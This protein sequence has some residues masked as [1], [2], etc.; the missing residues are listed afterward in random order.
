VGWPGRRGELASP[1][2]RAVLLLRRVADGSYRF[3]SD[4]EV[5]GG[6][7][8][9]LGLAAPDALGAVERSVAEEGALAALE[10][11][12]TFEPRPIDPP[13]ALGS[14]FTLLGR[15]EGGGRGGQPTHRRALFE[16]LARSAN[17]AARAWAIRG[18]AGEDD[19]AI[20]PLLA[21]LSRDPAPV[22]ALLPGGRREETTVGALAA[23]AFGRHRGRFHAISRL[24]ALLRDSQGL[25]P[26]RVA[27][28]LRWLT[29]ADLGPDPAAWER[30]WEGG[31]R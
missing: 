9:S 20:A 21:V 28:A 22:T 25:D 5:P 12:E 10:A 2:P 4:P 3:L 17:A 8:A 27:D 19:S 1:P 30:W 15:A 11:A 18:L 13:T 14:A 31:A 23:E 24:I 29:G 7:F 26:A 6:P 16:H